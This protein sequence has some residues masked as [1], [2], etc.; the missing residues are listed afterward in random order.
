MMTRKDYVATANILNNFVD[1]VD[2]LTLSRI[3]ENF[4]EMFENDNE[5]F[6][7]KRFIDAVFQ[8]EN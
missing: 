6:D 3:A 7:H 8:E 2:F 1:E 4:A 5:R